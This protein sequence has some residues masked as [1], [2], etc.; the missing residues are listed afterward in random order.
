MKKLER[1]GFDLEQKALAPGAEEVI[2]R[3]RRDTDEQT[4][5]R[6]DQRLRNSFRHETRITRTHLD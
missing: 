5:R 4:R 1:D 6:G 3:E 2:R